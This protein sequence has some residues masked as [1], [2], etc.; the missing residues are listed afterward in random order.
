MN[1]VKVTL[2][3]EPKGESFLQMDD[4]HTSQGFGER[5]SILRAVREKAARHKSS[6]WENM[7]LYREPASTPIRGT[8]VRYGGAIWARGTSEIGWLMG[9]TTAVSSVVRLPGLAM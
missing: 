9:R 4:G 7:Q 2:L 5:G 1:Y 8:A 3:S 6:F